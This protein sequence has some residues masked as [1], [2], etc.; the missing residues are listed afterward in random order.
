MICGKITR[1]LSEK[2]MLWLRRIFFLKC[3]IAEVWRRYFKRSLIFV[4]EIFLNSFFLPIFCVIFV[5]IEMYVLPWCTVHFIPAPHPRPSSPSLSSICSYP[6]PAVIFISAYIR[7]SAPRR[8]PISVL[9]VCVLT[10]ST[11]TFPAFHTPSIHHEHVL[12]FWFLN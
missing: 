9:N 3:Y 11:S 1:R 5:K 8:F 7:T 12:Q 10:V 2:C 4:C 6:S